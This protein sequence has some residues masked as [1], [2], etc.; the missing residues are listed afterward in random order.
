MGYGLW[1]VSRFYSGIGRV[2]VQHSGC[3]TICMEIRKKV[4]QSWDP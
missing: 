3:S 2:P 4:G 1:V